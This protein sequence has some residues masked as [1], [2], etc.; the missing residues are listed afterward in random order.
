MDPSTNGHM[1]RVAISGYASPRSSSSGGSSGQVA[2]RYRPP[3]AASPASST[4]ANPS[5]ARPRGSRRR[6]RP[7]QHPQHGIDRAHLGHRGQRVQ[8]RD[9]V[10]FA[11][12]VGDED[13]AGCPVRCLRPEI[14]RPPARS[15]GSRR[16]GPRTPRP[17]RPAHP[18]GRPP[19]GSRRTRSAARRAGRS[20]AGRN[21][22]RV[23]CVPLDR[24]AAASMTSPSTR[25]SGGRTTGTAPVEHE[26]AD[27][28]AL[29]EDGVEAVAHR[30]QR[31]VRG[32]H[33]RMHPHRDRAVVELLGEWPAA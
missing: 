7:R 13:Q 22:P 32:H 26:V 24:F 14:E 31:V 12:G 1:T 29:D 17:P 3:S 11:G 20:D 19:R 10:G 5:S 18:G 2:G 21:E 23:A 15:S 8:R 30:G 28:R 27:R 33:R 16:R 25:R 4:S 6:S 9:D